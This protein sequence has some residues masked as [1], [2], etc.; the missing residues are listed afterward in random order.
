[1]AEPVAAFWLADRH[2]GR[3]PEPH[4]RLLNG[5]HDRLLHER[6]G[7]RVP[8]RHRGRLPTQPTMTAIQA[9]GASLAL[10]E[11]RMG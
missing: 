11:A 3:L 8:E 7:G 6:H 9:I 2:G 5:P 10:S 4:G 1:M